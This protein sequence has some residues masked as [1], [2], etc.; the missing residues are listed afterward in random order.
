MSTTVKRKKLKWFGHVARMP[1]GRIP[2]VALD[3][4]PSGRRKKGRPA[5]TWRST[6][7]NELDEMGLTWNEAKRAAKDREEWKL[8]VVAL[9]SPRC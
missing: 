2:H 6:V 5:A 8:R 1:Q 3:W 7:K 4:T 9:C